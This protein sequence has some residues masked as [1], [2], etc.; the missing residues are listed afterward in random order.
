M[1]AD[2]W[3]GY[4]V[5]LLASFVG[6]M[7]VLRIRLRQVTRTAARNAEAAAMAGSLVKSFAERDALAVVAVMFQ[8][9][10]YG[11]AVMLPA[12]ED[13]TDGEVETVKR[14]WQARA[15]E[16]LQEALNDDG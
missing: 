10:S 13:E 3:G 2:W 12:Y 7:V 16:V 4:L 8:V 15:A 9:E 14:H 6:F 5:G 11:I 1:S